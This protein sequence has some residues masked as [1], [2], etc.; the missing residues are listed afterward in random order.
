MIA[1]C[2]D[3]WCPHHG[4]ARYYANYSSCEH[5]QKSGTLYALTELAA[6]SDMHTHKLLLGHR[7]FAC[8]RSVVRFFAKETGR[9]SATAV[10]ASR[11][12]TIL[13]GRQHTHAHTTWLSAI[14]S[15]SYLLS[16]VGV[17]SSIYLR[18]EPREI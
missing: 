2:R 1:S 4:A 14:L 8:T 12:E 3:L 9:N 7:D 5:P 16:Y 15:N 18:D 10:V 6:A 13:V 17:A 11:I